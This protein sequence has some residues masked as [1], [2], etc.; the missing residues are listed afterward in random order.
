M[1]EVT[2]DFEDMDSVMAYYG[3]EEEPLADFPFN[4]NLIDGFSNRSELTG[5]TLEFAINK[6]LDNMP[7]G[8]WANWVVSLY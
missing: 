6:W 5:S 4:F 7:D 3:T 8:K 2:Y 1:A